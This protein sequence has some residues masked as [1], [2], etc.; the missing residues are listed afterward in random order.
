MT[1]LLNHPAMHLPWEIQVSERLTNIYQSPYLQIVP[2]DDLGARPDEMKVGWKHR[3]IIFLVL[4]TV[5][6]EY[7]SLHFWSIGIGTGMQNPGV[8]TQVLLGL[9]YRLEN[10]YP[11]KTHTCAAGVRVINPYPNPYPRSGEAGRNGM[12]TDIYTD[13]CIQ[14]LLYSTKHWIHKKK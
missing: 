14:T 12:F 9:G 7:E 4:V 3:S 8:S 10:P 1:K 13:I 11:G 5:P 6:Q 2:C